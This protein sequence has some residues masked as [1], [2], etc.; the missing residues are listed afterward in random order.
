MDGNGKRHFAKASGVWMVCAVAL[1]M[2]ACGKKESSN[3]LP[4]EDEKTVRVVSMFSPMEK[5]E[6]DT[7]NTA[8][9]AA[10]KTVIM[11]EEELGIEVSYVTYTAE[12]YQDKTYDEVALDRA[13]SNMD[14]LYLLNPDTIR[15]LGEE[16]KLAD[17]SGLASAENLRDVVK[18]ANIVDGKLVAIPQ[19]VVA[20][21]LFIN[22]DM[23]DQYKL[24]L[25]NTPEE[26]LEC[27]RVLKENGIETPVGANRWWLETFVL[28]QAYADL[29]NG[30]NTEAEIAAL[31]SGESK[32][33]DY[34]RP[35][36]EFL[37]EMI[38][39]GYID[40]EKAYVSEAIEGE[41]AD[42]LAQKTPIVMAYWGA[43]NTDTAYGNPDFEMVV[44]GFPSSRGQMPVMPMTGFGVGV[45]AE[46][47]EDA[48]MALEVMT[49]DE[50]LKVYAE[51]NKVISPSRN[52]EVECIPA[53]KPL[54]DRIQENVYVL[55]ANASMNMEQWGNTCLVVRK[56]LGGA[57]VDECMAELDRLQEESNDPAR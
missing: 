25:P 26:F 22:K 56:L 13:R 46:H 1:A 3:I 47:K 54:N 17:L 53:L 48:L 8:R 12:D 10:D 9:S 28:A 55:G 39:K 43:A 51:T 40:A 32:Y 36:F 33:S 6:A 41:G 49:S 21:G 50:A 44:I 30:G 29:Y 7:V 2:T 35:G 19:E 57:T 15:A 18:A 27:C 31:N 42:F 5:T 16:G 20:Y 37:Q 38:D 34:M 11:A 23:F 14:D 24:K 52:V 4:M 45:D